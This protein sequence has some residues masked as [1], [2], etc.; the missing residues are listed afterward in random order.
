[1]INAIYGLKQAPHAWRAHLG[2]LLVYVDDIILVS[3]SILATTRLVQDLR[4]YF[5]VK[6]LGPLHYFQGACSYTQE[7]CLGTF[8][9]CWYASMPC[10]AMTSNEQLTSSDG[11]L[12]SS[13]DATTYRSIVGGL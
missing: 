7:V 11:D 13:E 8:L 2:F 6:D 10:C 3:S 1:M 9:L 5:A 12:L 4:S